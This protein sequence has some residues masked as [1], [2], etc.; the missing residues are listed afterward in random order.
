[1]KAK[2]ISII[3]AVIMLTSCGMGEITELLPVAA[4][5]VD[6]SGEMFSATA[7]IIRYGEERDRYLCISERGATLEE[8]LKKLEKTAEGHLYYKQ[9]ELLVLGKKCAELAG[10]NT[11]ASFR[12]L[13]NVFS[14]NMGVLVA[15]DFAEGLLS[16]SASQANANG[17]LSI[18][19]N[20]I[21]K[22]PLYSIKL[23]QAQIEDF[24]FITEADTK[25]GGISVGGIVCFSAGGMI[26]LYN[27]RLSD[28]IAILGGK[29]NE[30]SGY[31]SSEKGAQF[32][33]A[34]KLKV[35]MKAAGRNIAI[36]IYGTTDSA[37]TQKINEYVG[38]TVSDAYSFCTN[39]LAVDYFN[40]YNML[41]ADSADYAAKALKSGA[42]LDSKYTVA[43]N[44]QNVSN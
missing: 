27:K 28:G 20:G 6:L 31:I 16:L 32:F 40:Y 7:V 10:R 25:G 12:D 22:S 17:E 34:E 41:A 1:M 24:L 11:L 38:K 18:K 33:T 19:Y 39:I 29:L 14:P 37:E 30:I 36:E 42:I 3:A 13:Y 2:I 21:S 5:G 8:A 9:C 35:N 43:V 44:I 4:V 26:E 15:A 23:G